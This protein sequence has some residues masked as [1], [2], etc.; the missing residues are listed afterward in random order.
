[1]PYSAVHAASPLARGLPRPATLRLQGFFGP[2][3][4]SLLAGATPPC[5]RKGTLLGFS[6]QSFSRIRQPYHLSMAFAHLP[7]HQRFVRYRS[8]HGNRRARLL[9]LAPPLRFATP[10]PTVNRPRGRCSPGILSPGVS[11]PAN[12]GTGLP[13]PPP[14]RLAVHGA[15]APRP[16][17]ASE[18]HSICRLNV[19]ADGAVSPFGLLAPCLRSS[20]CGVAAS[21]LIV[22]PPAQGA[23][24]PHARRLE[25]RL[26]LP[27]HKE[28]AP[29]GESAKTLALT[30]CMVS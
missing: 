24:P 23:S 17:H 21:G 15:N 5:F 29:L 28:P 25:T 14:M 18:Y 26:R 12:D 2:P 22:S 8:S 4:A 9:G 11:L 19:P 1:M 13:A 27:A 6:L 16:A 30:I 7:L 20:D 3:D 10:E